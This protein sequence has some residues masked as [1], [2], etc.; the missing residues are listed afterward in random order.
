MIKHQYYSCNN[1]NI[2]TV[3][4]DPAS[5]IL[6]YIVIYCIRTT[7]ATATR[8]NELYA[9]RVNEQTYGKNKINCDVC[10]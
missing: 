2:I 6:Y 3:Q 5:N 8:T 7:L 4:Y 1:N 9:R 10:F